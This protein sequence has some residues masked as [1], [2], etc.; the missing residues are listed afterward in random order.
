MN[1]GWARR[2]HDAG[3]RAIAHLEAFYSK[4][5]GW[6]A[7]VVT[8]LY[9]AYGGGAA[10]FWVHARIRGESG[11]AISDI[12]HWLLDSTLGFVALAPSV[13][14]LLPMALWAVRRLKGDSLRARTLGFVVLV[15]TAFALVTVPGPALHNLLVGEGTPMSVLAESVLG[16]DPV[17]AAR[18]TRA[19]N[20]SALSESLV[21]LIVGVP[22]YLAAAALALLTVRGAADLRRRSSR[23]VARLTPHR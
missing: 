18:N 7:W 1:T 17:V 20:H 15:G 9:L 14:L 4:P 11:P 21:Q 19:P 13:F 5:L 22:V 10:L 6:A 3:T 12:S 8:T 23:R 16:Y 2:A